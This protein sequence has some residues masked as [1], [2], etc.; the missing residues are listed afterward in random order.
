MLVAVDVSVVVTVVRVKSGV[1]GV[2]VAVDVAVAV[3]VDDTV[4]V[5]VEKPSLHFLTEAR[6]PPPAVFL[7]SGH[8]SEA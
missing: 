3:P 6:A 5:A 7:A 4:L 2:D 1:A 8:V